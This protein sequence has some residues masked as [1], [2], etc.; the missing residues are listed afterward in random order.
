LGATNGTN[1]TTPASD[2]GWITCAN[3]F[4]LAPVLEN[5]FAYTLEVSGK[6]LSGNEG[7]SIPSA[8]ARDLLVNRFAAVAR[9]SW[10]VNGLFLQAGETRT[11]VQQLADQQA[12]TVEAQTCRSVSTTLVV[13]CVVGWLL[14]ALV[15]VVIVAIRISF[16][17]TNFSQQAALTTTV[18]EAD[19]QALERMLGDELNFEEDRAAFNEDEPGFTDISFVQA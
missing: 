7:R 2:L 4:E 15:V 18:T 5:G 12:V 8:A 10:I 17:K 3:A 1:A 19:L 14:F 16:R 9:H 13:I 6:D 11:L